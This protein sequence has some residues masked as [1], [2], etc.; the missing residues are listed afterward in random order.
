MNCSSDLKNVANS[1]PSASHFKSF[2]RSPEQFFLRVG[3]NNFGN[4]IPISG[5]NG[6]CY[7]VSHSRLKNGQNDPKHWE[8]FENLPATH[9]FVLD[10]VQIS[11]EQTCKAHLT[12]LD[13]ENA[14]L[15]PEIFKVLCATIVDDWPE[16]L[17]PYI[18]DEKLQVRYEL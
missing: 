13:P 17:K 12:N 8:E 7:T 14:N 16:E 11:D 10:R 1:W 5:T 15:Y 6:F 3:Q 18:L 4:K 2:S 9:A